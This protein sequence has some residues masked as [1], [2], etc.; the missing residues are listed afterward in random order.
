MQADVPP[1]DYVVYPLS[2]YERPKE[3]L[4]GKSVRS[5]L[6]TREG[7][8]S[9]EYSGHCEAL[10]HYKRRASSTKGTNASSKRTRTPNI[11]RTQSSCFGGPTSNP[12]DQQENNQDQVQAQKR[13]KSSKDDGLLHPIVDKG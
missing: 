9:Q 7:S 12:E 1:G 2:D 10:R 8:A 6:V 5:Q 3:Q 4:E 13:Q 11:G